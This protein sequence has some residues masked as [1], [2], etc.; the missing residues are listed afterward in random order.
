MN[1]ALAALSEHFR[2]VFDEEGIEDTHEHQAIVRAFCESD[3]H[4]TVQDLMTRAAWNGS[5]PT[6]EAVERIM[7]RICE[8]GLARKV[9]MDDGRILYEHLHLDQHHDHL[10]CTRCKRIV[11]FHDDRLE[12][13][14]ENVATQRSF[15]PFRHRLEIYGLCSDCLPRHNTTRT[16]TQVAVGERVRVVRSG[17]GSGFTQRMVDLGIVPDQEVQ[18]I[19]NTGPVI[20]AVGN[21]R[22]A[23]GRG[24]ASRILVK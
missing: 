17:G 20:V 13:L 18:V 3:S 19:N 24:M 2:M 7:G 9:V 15:F 14:K 11:N 16:L 6:E 10:I 23:L 12:E 5:R 22:I 21:T 1:E 4:Q 8:Y